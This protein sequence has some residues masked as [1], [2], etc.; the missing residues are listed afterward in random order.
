MRAEP[1]GHQIVGGCLSDRRGQ[2]FQLGFLLQIA[3]FLNL[4][5]VDIAQFVDRGDDG[6]HGDAI[7][8][9]HRF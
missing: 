1:V 8:D 6:S 5:A 3:V 7:L 9:Q 4:L 2:G